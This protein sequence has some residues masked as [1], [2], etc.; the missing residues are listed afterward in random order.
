MLYWSR[1]SWPGSTENRVQF[2]AYCLSLTHRV[3]SSHPVVEMRHSL[4]AGR[5]VGDDEPTEGTNHPSEAVIAELL[6]R[7]P[8]LLTQLSART[9][10]KSDA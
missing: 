1:A 7:R 10:V 2:K 9:N 4:G 8:E 3:G 5:H 6:E